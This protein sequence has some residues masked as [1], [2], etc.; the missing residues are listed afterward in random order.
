MDAFTRN[1]QSEQQ[2]EIGESQALK[3]I[4]LFEALRGG[5]GKLTR[6]HR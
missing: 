1:H 4:F 5:E 3:K 2:G 6:E